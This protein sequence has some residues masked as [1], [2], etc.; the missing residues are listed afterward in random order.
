MWLLWPTWEHYVGAADGKLE[1][2]TAPEDLAV[3]G[4]GSRAGAG[5]GSVW[6]FM[7][8]FDVYQVNDTL[9]LSHC[10]SLSHT[11]ICSPMH[12]PT[13]KSFTHP[14]ILFLTF[15]LYFSLSLSLVCT[16]VRAC[17]SLSPSFSHFCPCILSQAFYPSLCIFNTHTLA[18]T[19]SHALSHPVT[20]K[21]THASN[22]Y[23]HLSCTLTHISLSFSLFFSLSL[24]LSLSYTHTLIHTHTHSHSHALSL[25]HSLIHLFI[26]VAFAS[27][28]VYRSRTH[29]RSLLSVSLFLPPF[30][31]RFLSNS[32]LLF[33]HPPLARL[34]PRRLLSIVRFL[35]F[36]TP[37]NHDFKLK[38]SNSHCEC[39]LSLSCPW[40][41]LSDG[42][43]EEKNRSRDKLMRKDRHLLLPAAKFR[44]IL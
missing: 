39:I 38:Q 1:R 2:D 37:G 13:F 6:D 16:S 10:V 44:Y 11:G 34:L 35:S 42:T 27:C 31:V 14:L 26:V 5:G 25:I 7:S 28:V 41:F 33:S 20:H 8:R 29:A 43:V 17:V 9:C 21:R 40:H 3:R 32:F 30:L 22:L 36:W 15:L 4:R 12:L 18:H 19:Q 24:S 23:P